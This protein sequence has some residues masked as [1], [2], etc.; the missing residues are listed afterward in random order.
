MSVESAKRSRNCGFGYVRGV[1]DVTC[2][3]AVGIP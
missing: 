1:S 3:G 2:K